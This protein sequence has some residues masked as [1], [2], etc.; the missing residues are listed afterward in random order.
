LAHAEENPNTNV[1][2]NSIR[3]KLLIFIISPMFIF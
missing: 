3:I 1:I 2:V